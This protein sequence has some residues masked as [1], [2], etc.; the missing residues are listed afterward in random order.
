LYFDGFN[1]GVLEVSFCDGNFY[2]RYAV[3]VNGN[4]GEVM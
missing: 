4:A 3:R 1:Q 2:D